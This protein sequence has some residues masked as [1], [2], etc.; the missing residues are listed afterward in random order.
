M[1]SKQLLLP[2][3]LLSII[4]SSCLT[5]LNPLVTATNI[6]KNDVLIGKWK[7]RDNA[8][9]IEPMATSHLMREYKWN[10]S[11]AAEPEK[12][13]SKM[14]TEE[15]RLIRNSY[16]LSYE[17]NSLTHYFVL[18]LTQINKEWYGD[19]CPVLVA[20]DSTAVDMPQHKEGSTV[21]RLLPKKEGPVFQFIDG[22]HLQLLLKNGAVRIRHEED[23]LFGTQF[24]SATSEELQKFMERYG[25]DQ[26]LYDPASTITLNRN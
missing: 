14:T 16:I 3:T 10:G 25:K 13:I 19:L 1:I 4:L 26:R 2:V 23:E 8:I 5:T 11:K 15:Q 20:K 22:S 24:I 6:S 21:F 18:K 12:E 17:K 7:A 9:T